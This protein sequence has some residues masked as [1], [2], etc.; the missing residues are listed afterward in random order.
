M[1]LSARTEYAAL[2]VLELARRAA[3]DEP[4]RIRAICEA[5][6]VPSGFLVQI[7]LQLK[8]AGIVTSTRG[9]A[10]GYQLA[11]PSD[12]ITLDDVRRAVEGQGDAV[13]PVTADL[14]ERS[15]PA[16]VLAAAW[17]EA[18]LAEGE[19]LRSISF[20]D[21]ADRCR[22]SADAMYYI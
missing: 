2:A 10:G 7:L 19:V 17:T 4:V 21:L 9:A 8:A 11:R 18:A 5:Q 13:A 6:G 12:E 3:A 14:A 15:R 1:R 20:A 22:A 16:G